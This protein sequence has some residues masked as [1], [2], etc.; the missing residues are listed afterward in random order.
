MKQGLD[1]GRAV[2]RGLAAGL[3]LGP[4]PPP[5][6]PGP[7]RGE[8]AARAAHGKGGTG[9]GF[10]LVEL[11][12]AIG[13]LAV[14]ATISWRALASLV[15]TRDR[16][17]PEAEEVRAMLVAVG[18]VERDLAAAP[19]GPAMFTL[20]APAVQLAVVD[21]RQTLAILRVAPARPGEGTALQAV[22]YFV[23]DGA[24]V[25]RAAAPTRVLGPATGATEDAVLLAGVGE[26]QLRFWRQGSG[27]VVPAVGDPAPPGVELV[28][29]RADGSTLRRVLKVG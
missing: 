11:L 6:T 22:W 10:T 3:R 26:L 14:V 4:S 5:L 8:V 20:P 21:G 16:L 2:V 29:L 17:G 7:G 1:E 25:R 15:A 19:A 28:L 27:W 13:I 12:V 24:L 9:G 23:Q 18:Q